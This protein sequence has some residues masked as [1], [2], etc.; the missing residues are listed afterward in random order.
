M[1]QRKELEQLRLRKEQLVLQSEANRQ[2][3]MSDWQR[4]QS[5]EIWLNEVLGLMRRHPMWL[6]AL[7]T[8]AGTLVAKTLR[9]PRTIINRIGQ[10]GKFASIAFSAWRL[11]RRKKRTS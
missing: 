11:F 5:S 4:L 3:L 1:F 10:V 9:Q 7:A 2:R 6:A 8:A